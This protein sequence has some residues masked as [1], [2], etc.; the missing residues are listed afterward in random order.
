M[1]DMMKTLKVLEKM[2]HLNWKYLSDR[3]NLLPRVKSNLIELVEINNLL[4]DLHTGLGD[5]Q[6]EFNNIQ[7]NQN[8]R[9]S[10]TQEI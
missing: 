2:K 7:N 5:Y 6:K 1:F 8:F 9:N 10:S 3:K 4:L